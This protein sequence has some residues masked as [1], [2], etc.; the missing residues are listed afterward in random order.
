M[1]RSS[2]TD[3]LR[4]IVN[5]AA[6]AGGTDRPDSASADTAGTL[7]LGA[8]D[9]QSALGGEWRRQG[10]SHCFVVERRARPDA[11]HG[12]RR[13][14]DMA[15]DLREATT[16]GSLIADAD[17]RA[18]LVFFDV[19]TTGLGGGA[20][21]YAFLVGC[22]RF[23]DEG[24]FVTRQFVLTRQADEPGL[25]RM[26]R[27]ELGTA[28]GLVTFNGKSFDAPLIETRFS[29]HRLEWI[30]GRLAHLDMLHPSRRFWGDVVLPEPS[31]SLAAL[32]RTILGAR[33]LGDVSGHEVPARFFRFVRTSD[34]QPLVGV[35]EHNRLDLLSLAGLTARLLHLVRTGSAAARTAGEAL[36]LGTLYARSDT[37]R[38]EEAFQRAIDMCISC[39][40]PRQNGPTAAAAVR[41]LARFYRRARRFD[42][43]AAQWRR[44]LELECCP[45]LAAREASDALAVHHEHRARDL[46]LAKAFAVRSLVDVE[47]GAAWDR[48]VRHRL[49]RLERKL[50]APRNATLGF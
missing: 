32:E 9:L 41:A 31:C 1:I 40:R 7:P 4:A 11:R 10:N 3:R 35:L 43:A 18:P 30:G 16:G 28:G 23:D 25:L 13:V 27:S 39:A 42:D 15:Q 38:A 34:P 22:G 49:A 24:A 26:L 33:R 5:P 48:A 20:G 14:A 8:I 6:R 12:Y 19:E 36:A 37:V 46:A 50:S 45:A 21:T 44:L 17:V 29:F 2:F 47:P